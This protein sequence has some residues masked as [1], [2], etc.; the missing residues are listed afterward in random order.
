MKGNY[1]KRRFGDLRIRV[2]KKDKPSYFLIWF[3]QFWKVWNFS[4]HG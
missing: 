3:L 2:L 4:L 1:F